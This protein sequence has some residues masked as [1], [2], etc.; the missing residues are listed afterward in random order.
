VP[1]VFVI[2]LAGVIRDVGCRDAELDRAV[3]ALL[4]KGKGAGGK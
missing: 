3:D 1:E 4:A 2:D